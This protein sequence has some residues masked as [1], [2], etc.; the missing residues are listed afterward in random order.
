MRWLLAT[1]LLLLAGCGRS[2]DYWVGQLKD[3]DV[4]KRRQA[5]RELGERTSEAPRVVAAL[6]EALRDEN[7]YV[8]HDCATALAKFGPEAQPAVP[9]LRAALK[10]RDHNV[11]RAAETALKKI[12]PA[13]TGKGEGR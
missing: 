2:T 4:V 8:R 7:E 6:T 5:V 11:R 9:A 13:A 1:A 3:A 10:D 12:A